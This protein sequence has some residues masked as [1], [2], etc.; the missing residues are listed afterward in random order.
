[1][2]RADRI[3]HPRSCPQA[4]DDGVVGDAGAGDH[5]GM[6]L[7]SIGE[8]LARQSGV[9]SR[10]QLLGLGARPHD[11]ARLIRRR[12][13]N[14]LHPGVYVEHT[15]PPSWTQRTWAAV[16][17][18]WPAALCL[19]SALGHEPATGGLWTPGDASAQLRQPSPAVHTGSPIQVAVALERRV[20]VHRRARLDQLVQ[21]NLGPPRVRYE[22][23]V[24][25]LAATASSEFAVVAVLAEACRSRRTT[26]QRLVAALRERHRTA[27]RAW[28]Y[29]VLADLAAGTASVLEHRYLTRVERAHGLPP[30]ARQVR[31]VSAT[32]VVYRDVE[33]ATGLL[34]ELDGRL[35]H[36]T[37]TQRDADFE[38][39]LDAAVGGRS[40]IRLS[41]GQVVDRPCTT[42]R[43]LARLLQ[44]RGWPGPPRP[45]SPGCPIEPGAW[46]IGLT[47]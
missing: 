25:D 36:N 1:V 5:Q 28:L 2:R 40:T 16:L 33:Y 22:H 30:A 11:I 8:L 23:T 19:E 24:L 9:I 14:R 42:A 18:V 39:D 31:A 41:W 17:A 6:D 37:A 15:G 21:W 34:V 27:R 3:L 4:G 26:P 45:C 13:L 7:G 47:G 20:L 43:K 10:S 32:G 46:R 29:A 35:V 38:R 44:H 12:E